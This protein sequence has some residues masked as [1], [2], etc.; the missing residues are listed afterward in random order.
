MLFTALKVRLIGSSTKVIQVRPLLFFR[1]FFITNRIDLPS[2][3]APQPAFSALRYLSVGVSSARYAK[4]DASS[5]FPISPETAFSTL[6]HT[7][8]SSYF[9]CQHYLTF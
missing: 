1:Q 3:Q 2:F 8:T 5:G 7:I 9:D 4:R 6:L